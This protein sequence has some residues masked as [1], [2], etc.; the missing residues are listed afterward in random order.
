MYIPSRLMM[1]SMAAG[2]VA[3][4]GL[5]AAKG[6]LTGRYGSTAAGAA[7]GAGWGM[8]SGDTSVL[9]GAAMGAGIGRYG[10][11]GLRAAAKTGRGLGF[12]D[13]AK[14][15]GI[16]FGGGVLNRMQRDYRGARIATNKMANKIKGLYNR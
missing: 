14:A 10:A 12:R 16:G 9:G 6:V 2:H 15:Y 5:S 11:A 4:R 7:W 13:S 3:M 8:A 1:G